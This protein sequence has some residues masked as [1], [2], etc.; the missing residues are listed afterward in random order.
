[1]ANQ[2]GE[3]LI[4]PMFRM[5]FFRNRTQDYLINYKKIVLCTTMVDHKN[6]THMVFRKNIFCTLFFMSNVKEVVVA[7]KL[8]IGVF[9]GELPE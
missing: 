9:N 1:M 4:K 8:K 6:I 3:H 2:L 7:K 5:T